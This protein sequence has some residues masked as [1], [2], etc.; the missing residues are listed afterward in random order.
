[1][2]LKRK[3]FTLPWLMSLLSEMTLM[4]RSYSKGD[5][6][7]IVTSSPTNLISIFLVFVHLQMYFYKVYML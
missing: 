4:E 6:D 5:F 2:A 3:I 7:K 1:M